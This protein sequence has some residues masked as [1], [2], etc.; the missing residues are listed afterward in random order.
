MQFN[1][2]DLC[3]CHRVADDAE[4][5]SDIALF[6]K[7]SNGE[8]ICVFVEATE[9]YIYLAASYRWTGNET[10]VET[11]DE[12]LLKKNKW[13]FCT[14][15]LCPCKVCKK[16]HQDEC[17]CPKTKACWR[18]GALPCTCPRIAQV[19]INS[20]LCRLHRARDTRAVLGIEPVVRRR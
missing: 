14:R 16:C 13:G 10:L 7:L 17:V 15:T 9:Y 1:L 8:T 2:F 18:C 19:A 11:L 5:Q 6:G 3:E 12:A 20:D 4:A